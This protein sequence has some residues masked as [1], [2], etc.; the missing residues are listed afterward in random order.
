MNARPKS[1]QLGIDICLMYV[2]IEKQ[3]VVV[4]STSI[5]YHIRLADLEKLCAW[6]QFGTYRRKT[7]EAHLI[8]QACKFCL[9]IIE[10]KG[11]C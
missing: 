7:S 3:D 9:S 2:E 5:F 8:F 6:Y 10:E 4:V 1:K 11:K